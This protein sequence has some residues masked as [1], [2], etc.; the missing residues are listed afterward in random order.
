MSPNQHHDIIIIGGSYAGLSAGMALGRSLR[1][2]LIIDSGKPCNRQTPH[3][4][5]LITHD[6]HPPVEIARQAREQVAS[7]DTVR[8]HEG[9][10]T[11]GSHTPDGFTITTKAG[12]TFSAPKLIFATGLRDIMPTIPGFADCWGITVIHCPYCHGYEVRQ[13]RT[14]ILANGAT[15]FHYVQLLHNWTDDL[16]L[17]TNGPST[18]SAEQ[19]EAIQKR[20]IPIVEKGIAALDHEA[21]KLNK[22]TFTDGTTFPLTALYSSPETEQHCTIP[23]QLGC[24]VTEEGLLQV[25][26]FQQTTVPGVFACGD[27]ATPFRAL[28][29]AIAAGTTAG[30]MAN[31]QMAIAEFAG[32]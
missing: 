4:H 28:S 18:L 23:A 6:G 8:F 25:D 2:V 16:T 7:Y 17:F 13:K 24:V 30:A 20:G 12:A 11:S 15:A 5:N 29:H 32:S 31:S 10:A 22:I 1:R 21:G 26:A 19:R 9:L 14:G 27:N 3:A